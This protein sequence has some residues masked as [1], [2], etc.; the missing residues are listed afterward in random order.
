MIT[1]D[2]QAG[3]G[4]RNMDITITTITAAMSCKRHC[5]CQSVLRGGCVDAD[6]APRKVAVDYLFFCFAFWIGTRLT[7]TYGC[8][9]QTPS[10]C[11][12]AGYW[13]KKV[14]IVF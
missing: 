14:R 10:L 8:S 12:L 3:R 6:A 4:S 5:F 2:L 9:M 11:S 1:V 7:I 13:R